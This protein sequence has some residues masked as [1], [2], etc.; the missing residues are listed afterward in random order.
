MSPALYLRHPH[1][2]THYIQN[3]SKLP[4][5]IKQTWEVLFRIPSWLLTFFH[6]THGFYIVIKI[7][8]QAYHPTEARNWIALQT[9][10]LRQP[11]GQPDLA[12]NPV[13]AGQLAF[14]QI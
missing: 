6:I 3:L 14:G 11:L 5:P 10:F 7:G 9:L 13:E 2:F 12:D 4:Q 1:C 8:L